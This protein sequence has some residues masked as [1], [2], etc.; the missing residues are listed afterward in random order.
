MDKHS[1]DSAIVTVVQES[2]SSFFLQKHGERQC[3]DVGWRGQSLLQGTA[4][5]DTIV[6]SG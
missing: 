5:L 6:P 1:P 4:Q 3:A 2:P